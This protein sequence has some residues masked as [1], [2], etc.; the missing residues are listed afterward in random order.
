MGLGTDLGSVDKSLRLL[1]IKPRLL[2]RKIPNIVTASTELFRIPLWEGIIRI[3]KGNFQNT[4]GV[5]SHAQPVYRNTSALRY[6]LTILPNMHRSHANLT[7][8]ERL[9]T[10]D[11]RREREVEYLL[12]CDSTYLLLQITTTPTQCKHLPFRR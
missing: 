12:H 9:D 5:N 2:T 11:I 4:H 6:D 3:P 7:D 10:Q 1:G 8:R